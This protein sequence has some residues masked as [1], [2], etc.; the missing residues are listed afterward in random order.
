MKVSRSACPDTGEEQIGEFAE[1]SFARRD[2]AV[3]GMPAMAFVVA[4]SR[5]VGQFVPA[6]AGRDMALAV[7]AITLI[8]IGYLLSRVAW[9]FAIKAT[10]VTS[11]KAWKIAMLWVGLGPIGRLCVGKE[12]KQL[13]QKDGMCGL[14]LHRDLPTASVFGE[15]RGE[16]RVAY[17]QQN[18]PGV[19][20]GLLFVGLSAWFANMMWG[21][22][23]AVIVVLAA[24]AWSLPF[25]LSS[26]AS[27]LRL[28]PKV[29]YAPDGVTVRRGL[30]SRIYRPNRDV[31]YA[32]KSDDAFQTMHL[33]FVNRDGDFDV[34]HVPNSAGRRIIGLWTK[35]DRASR[36]GT[37]V[38]A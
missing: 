22:F 28:W 6:H 3:I 13:V 23:E 8:A 12:L 27:M 14:I 11:P 20:S 9:L 35:C 36:G 37:S 7:V 32:R 19:V 5:Y 29:E 25:L 16:R 15:P 17:G 34:A 33:F 21:Q 2:G 26:L 1:T 30:R 24:A 4:M 38:P 31:L 10:R 18:I